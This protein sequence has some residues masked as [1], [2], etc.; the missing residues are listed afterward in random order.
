MTEVSER[1]SRIP[2]RAAEIAAR[3]ALLHLGELLS[4]G[5]AHCVLIICAS[6]VACCAS[7]SSSPPAGPKPSNSS[8]DDRRPSPA[9]RCLLSPPSDLSAAESRMVGSMPSLSVGRR[10]RRRA[11][12]VRLPCARAG[13]VWLA[14][15]ARPLSRALEG[16]ATAASAA[17]ACI[18]A[19]C[20]AAAFRLISSAAARSAPPWPLGRLRLA[21]ASAACALS[22]A[23]SRSCARARAR[24]GRG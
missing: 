24:R 11:A 21:I 10:G 12:A 17:I 8:L 3:P 6:R 4:A 15:A 22:F 9:Q 13:S 14:E 18:S 16:P 1:R 19:A 5:S 23:S 20:S 7:I 2:P